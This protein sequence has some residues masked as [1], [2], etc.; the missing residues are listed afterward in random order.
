MRGRLTNL[1]RSRFESGPRGLLRYSFR[2]PVYLYHLEL[3]WIFGHRCL[4]LTHQGRKSGLL[5]QTVLEVVSHDPVAGES[6][7]VSAWG[8]KAQWYRNISESPALEVQTARERYVPLQRFLT[9]EESYAVLAAYEH[10]HP[11][12]IRAF[13]RLLSRPLDGSEAALRTFV[14][15]VRLVAFRPR[16]VRGPAR[17]E[18]SETGGV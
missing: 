17:R 2:L 13:A 8:E 11:Y 9:T 14:E 10:V 1:F 7:V 5:R 6:F 16:D 18:S 3:G 4:M 12:A 15:G